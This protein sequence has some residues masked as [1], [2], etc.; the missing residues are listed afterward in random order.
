MANEI[1]HPAG[2]RR[3]RARRRRQPGSNA[4]LQDVARLAEVS[5]MSVSL[6][7]NGRAGR[8]AP[9][10]RD[11]IEQ[12]IARV[13]YRPNA[14]A[15][16]LR[17]ARGTSVGMIILDAAP[18][19]LA[20]PFTTQLVAGLSNRLSEH[21]YPLSLQGIPP[22]QIGR[23][24]A[25]RYAGV[26]GLCILLGG[27]EADRRRVMEGV[28]AL[29]VPVV[30]FQEAPSAMPDCCRVCQDDYAG[31]AAIARH[32]IAAGARHLAMLV[33]SQTWYSMA[34][35][36]RGIHDVVR[37]QPDATVQELDCGDESVL[38][39]RSALAAYLDCKGLPDAVVAGN[40]RMATAALLELRKRGVAIPQ[41]VMVTGFNG[42]PPRDV[43]DPLLT[44]VQSPAYEMGETGAEAML[45]RLAT[46]R[47]DR[48]DI[49]LPVRF[50]P[51]E[52]TR[53]E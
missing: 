42:F 26:D 24:L 39:T 25:V 52:S 21:G 22:T 47:F 28:A 12:A 5:L 46:G 10:T 36:R 33:P 4:T 15:R 2:R 23:A 14:A 3:E 51:G 45:R 18:Q 44:T 37:Q 11:R 50:L 20:A 32:V 31:G 13:N 19:F 30:L 40:D 41:R 49:Q 16:S 53:A 27:A 38:R 17:L 7:V 48:L 35:R 29:G 6:V 8:L 1:L 43:V 34:E 9:E